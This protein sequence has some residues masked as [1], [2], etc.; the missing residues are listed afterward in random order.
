MKRLLF[1]SDRFRPW[2]PDEC[3]VNP[4]VLGFELA[5]WLSRELAA[6]SVVTSYPEHE[7]WGWYLER[8]EDGVEYRICCTGGEYDGGFEWSV[9]VACTKGVFRRSTQ[10]ET[11]DELLDAVRNLLASQG[12]SA[13]IERNA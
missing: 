4:N 3:Q 8:S 7:D 13:E 11:C 10:D 5:A 12:I 1:H 6:R 9:F 2:L